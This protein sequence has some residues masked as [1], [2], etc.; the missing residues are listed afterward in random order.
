M[1]K[2]YKDN[3]L[4]GVMIM[5]VLVTKSLNIAKVI[6]VGVALGLASVHAT[7]A[8]HDTKTY[9]NITQKMFDNCIRNHKGGG[10]WSVYSG[11][12]SGELKLYGDKIPDSSKWVADG[13]YK[14]DPPKLTYRLTKFSGWVALT[15]WSEFWAGFDG[16][17]KRCESSR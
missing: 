15:P 3:T 11:G 6:V 14:F 8:N 16:T 9:S 7:A 17:M 4:T 10:G 13:E 1:G 5:A 2:T 12:N